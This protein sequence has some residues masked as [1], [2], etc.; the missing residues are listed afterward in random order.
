MRCGLVFAGADT[1]GW[2]AASS[3][4]SAKISRPTLYVSKHIVRWTL[5]HHTHVAL[6]VIVPCEIV[7]K[8]MYS[9]S[10][11]VLGAV[12]IQH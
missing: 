9:C 6:Y 5:V 1:S 10:A 11:F 12:H 8:Y 2:Y 3:L 7:L 4:L